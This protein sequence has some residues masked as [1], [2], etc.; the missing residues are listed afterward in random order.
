MEFPQIMATVLE[1]SLNAPLAIDPGSEQLLAELEG[2]VIAMNIESLDGHFYL[3]PHRDRVS[4]VVDHQWYLHEERRSGRNF[5]IMLPHMSGN[6][7]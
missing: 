2:R 7:Y 1:R 4:I 3:L 5:Q 6:I